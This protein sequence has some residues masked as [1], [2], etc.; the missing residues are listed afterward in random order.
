MTNATRVIDA[1]GHIGEP[2]AVWEEYTEPEF[3]SRVP[4]VARDADGIDRIMIDDVKMGR[5][6]GGAYPI[7]AMCL[8]GGL[9][10]P[11]RARRL[12]WEDL[13]PGSY[14]PHARIKD[15]DGEGIDVS[16]LFPSIGVTYASVKDPKLAAAACRGYNNWMADF[17]RPYPD[18]LFNAAPVPLQD[19]GEAIVEMRRVVKEHGVKAVLV[20]PNPHNDRHFNDPAYDPFWAQAQ[21]LN[22]AIAV[23][24]GVGGDMPTVGFDRYQD[25]FRRM[26]ISHPMEQ[27]LACMD[28]I[29]GGVLE[30]Y[31]RLRVAFLE[32]G[33]AWVPYWLDRMDEF[34]EKLPHMV[35]AMKMKPS[36]YFERQCFCSC[37]PEDVALK[38]AA[39]TGT[40]KI[41][42]WASDY[43][44]FDCTYPG[45]V[46]ELREHCEALPEESQRRI[47][48]ENAT[49]CYSLG[50]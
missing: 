2:R 7:A 17:C 39:I 1:D 6:S 36:E 10:D 8:P 29:C 31:P 4:R 34:F 14:D 22:C 30:K 15:M 35:P 28:L 16:I 32:A 40:D 3:R 44:H 23:H 9:S 47:I 50:R 41:L 38:I 25:F 12:A 48:G 24:G 37:E 11:Q 42:M 19:V 45:V 33:G 49:H 46:S 13:R 20:R 21:E 27:Q 43:P 26:M 5:S 18:R